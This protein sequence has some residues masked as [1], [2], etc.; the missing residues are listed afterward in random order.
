VGFGLGPVL[1]WPVERRRR[2]FLRLGVALTAAFVVLRGLNSYG[3]PAPWA[4]Q[5]S[6][7]VTVLS[8]LNTTKY[9]PSLLFLL[10]TL[11][12]ALIMVSALDRPVPAPLRPVLTIGKVPLFFFVTHLV[13]IHGLAVFICWM[14]YGSVHWMFESPDLSHFPITEPPGW[15]LGLPAVYLIWVLVVV[16]LYPACRWYA[17]VKARSGST[18]LS[19]I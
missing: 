17:A 9:P 6:A 12:P 15:P 19:Y 16:A 3:D 4:I 10:M 5:R 13:V 14:R 2:L 11:G 7:I 8:F 18:W 1:D